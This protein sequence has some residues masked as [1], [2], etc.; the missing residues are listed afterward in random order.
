MVELKRIQSATPADED[1]ILIVGAGLAGLFLALRLAPRPV[2]VIAPAPLGEAASSAWAQGGLAAA[3]DPLDSPET[4]ASDT[5]AAGAGLVDPVI[6]RLIAEEGPARVLDLIALGVPFDRT[7]EGALA[8]SLEAAHSHPRVARVAGDLA[9]KAIMGALTAAVKDAEHIT[10]KWPYRAVSLL[11]DDD[12]RISGIVTEDKDG[13]LAPLTAR[14]TVLCT[15]GSG[16]LFRVTTN[17]PQSRGDSIAMAWKA[18]A[19]ISDPEFV[20]FHPTAMDVGLDP[21]PLA[22]EALRGEGAILRNHKGVPFMA[23]YHDKAELAPRDEVA[24]AIHSEISA[25]KGAFLDATVA[26]GKEFPA[27][28]PTVFAACMAAGIDPRIK[29]IPVAPAAHYHMG[30]VVADAWGSSTLE[31]LSVCGECSSTGAHGANRL[32][33]NSLLEAVVFAERIAERLK[34]T[35]L[36]KPG[37]ASAEVAPDLPAD[38][39]MTLRYGMAERCGVVRTAE[40]LSA[41]REEIATL[42]DTHGPARA[43]VTA[44]LMVDAALQREESRG[45][46]FRSDFPDSR[47]LARRTFLT[48]GNGL[49]QCER[50][51]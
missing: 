48:R 40:G 46:H 41:L 26:V 10:L 51:E 45:G 44:Q 21:A 2:T 13:H 6:A 15:G 30:G 17:P 11:Q 43:L 9:G 7:P 19:L 14:H 32:A 12:G 20:Q 47:Q 25:G 23:H 5:V 3:L 42:E 4:H 29:P 50:P 24:R 49:H 8:L 27:H 22:T 1:D 36:T 33:S 31:A 37:A 34:N 39:L 28:F 16:G 38:A 35:V 18:G